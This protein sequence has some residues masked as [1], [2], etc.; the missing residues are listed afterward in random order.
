MMTKKQ[1]L[2][3]FRSVIIP[4]LEWKD[5][6]AVRTAWNDYTDYLCKSGFITGKQYDTWTNPF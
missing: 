1:A 4:N 5:P 2:E 6:T 3:E